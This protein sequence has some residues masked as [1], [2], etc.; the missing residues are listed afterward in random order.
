M[1]LGD[2]VK[3]AAY[4]ALSILSLCCDTKEPKAQVDN[5]LRQHTVSLQTV[6]RISN[7]NNENFFQ[8][9][10]EIKGTQ[11]NVVKITEVVKDNLQ[12]MNIEIREIKGVNSHLVNCNAQL[13]QKLS[14]Y[15]QLKE[16]I[17]YL[18]SLCTHVK[19]Y[20]ATFFAEKKERF[21]LPSRD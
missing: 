15:Q 3:D 4:S 20:R 9:V 11:E 5:L 1:I 19:L 2:P 13:A 14:F 12:M 7:R 8:L 6:E 21:S 16:F 10:D 17:I 18:N